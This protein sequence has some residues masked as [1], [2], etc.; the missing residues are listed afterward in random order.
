MAFLVKKD[1][2]WEK[3]PIHVEWV[4]EKV[5]VTWVSVIWKG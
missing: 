2:N 4:V 3:E 5:R 1:R